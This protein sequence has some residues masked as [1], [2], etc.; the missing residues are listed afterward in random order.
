M[1]PCFLPWN[2]LEADTEVGK[3]GGKNAHFKISQDILGK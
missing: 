2:N 3:K 1:I